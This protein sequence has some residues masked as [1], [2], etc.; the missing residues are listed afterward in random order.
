MSPENLNLLLPLRRPY[1]HA[2]TDAW[3]LG[4]LLCAMLAHCTPWGAAAPADALWA[5]HAAKPGFRHTLPVSRAVD[6]MLKGMLAVREDARWGLGRVR[7]EVR[8]MCEWWMREEEIRRHGGVLA[9]VAAEAAGM[10]EEGDIVD[11]WAGA[12]TSAPPPS[13]S[14]RGS[15]RV[16]NVSTIESAGPATPDAHPALAAA[17]GGGDDD[18]PPLALDGPVGQ[19]LGGR[20][21]L[22]K[23]VGIPGLGHGRPVMQEV[24]SRTSSLR[25]WMGSMWRRASR[26]PA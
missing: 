19:A 4:V 5:A 11:A 7:R 13:L 22:L 9:L 16:V 8:G 17:G 24:S 26:V 2:R 1:S 18:V 12:L 6:K 10:A 14:G 15:L 21:A 20:P 23:V 25:A 3:A